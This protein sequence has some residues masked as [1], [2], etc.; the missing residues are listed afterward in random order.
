MAWAALTERLRL[1]YLALPLSDPAKQ[2][3]VGFVY[4]TAGAAFRGTVHFEAWKR[5]RAA[6]V[7][8]PLPIAELPEDQPAP[9]VR[10]EPAS[11]RPLV[12]IIVCA[13]HGYGAALRCLH[14]IATH[15]PVAPFE[16]I[17]VDDGCH[18]PEM[19]RLSQV[20]GL[21]VH[22]EPVPI[23]Y[24]RCCNLAADLARGEYLHFLSDQILVHDGWLD[25]L[26]QV[27]EARPDCA[28][29]GPKLLLPNGRLQAAG[30]VVWRDGTAWLFGHGDDPGR[31]DYN[32]LRETDYCSGM[33]ILVPNKLFRRLGRFTVSDA[34]AQCEDVDFSFKARAGGERVYFQPASWVYFKECNGHAADGVGRSVLQSAHAIRASWATTLDQEHRPYDQG[35]RSA[36]EHLRPGRTVLV[37]DRYVPRPDRDGGSRTV[38]EFIKTLVLDDWNVKFW[39]HTLWYESDY[40]Q[41][42]QALGVEVFYGAE[43]ANR[44]GALLEELDGALAAV[45]IN[46]PLVARD[47]LSCVRRHSRAKLVYYGHDIHYLRLRE[48]AR[49]LGVRPNREQRLMSRLEPRIWKLSDLIL[50]PS[51]AEAAEVRALDSRIDARSIPSMAFDSFAT[52]R[53]PARRGRATL[54]MVASYSH[55]PNRDGALWLLREVLP[56]LRQRAVPFELKLVGHNVPSDL[57]ALA[58]GDVNLVGPVSEAELDQLYQASDLAVV[59]LRYG[60]GVK[61]K[62]V[63]AL[64]WGL[65]LVTTP[66]GAQGLA[67]VEQIVPVCTDPAQFARAIEHVLAD[68]IASQRMSEQMI[69]FAR[70]RF[71]REA[72]RIALTDALRIDRARITRPYRPAPVNSDLRVGM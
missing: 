33:A 68:A 2:R 46:R 55:P 41:R 54:L 61:G 4:R 7:A 49:V 62:V 23:G 52:P 15:A 72:M 19:T 24:A 50:Y 60:A 12:S 67:G 59:P 10:F 34:P 57:R 6:V 32:Y 37:V 70:A 27:F 58:G 5:A 53:V 30:G 44:F 69:E 21:R 14:R 11:G 29:A 13:Q 22:S 28:L 9:E 8:A 3:L 39:P 56:I 45:L 64:R 20:R 1:I 40:T 35:V 16:V 17:L 25:R 47:Y 51:D 26:L 31:A 18:D 48:Q 66:A 65:P 36:R 42:L 43:N 38:W 63:E 71:S